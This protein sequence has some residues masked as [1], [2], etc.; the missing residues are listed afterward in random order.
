MFDQVLVP[1]GPGTLLLHGLLVFA[2]LVGLFLALLR[3]LI[4]SLRSNIGPEAIENPVRANGDDESIIMPLPA[5]PIEANPILV[6]LIPV[7]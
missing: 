6:N 3:W 1:R 2:T 5:N 7:T 4:P